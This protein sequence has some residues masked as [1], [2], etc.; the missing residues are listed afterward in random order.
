MAFHDF[1]TDKLIVIVN[2][3][4]LTD[5]GENDPP[6][7]HDFPSELGV[8]RKGMGGGAARLDLVEPGQVFN[9]YLQPGSPDSAFISV[10]KLSRAT[11]TIAHSQLGTLEAGLGR[12]GMIKNRQSSGRGGQT[13]TDDVF[14]IECNKYTDSTGG[15]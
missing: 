8:M 10:L 1:S 3:R 7:D 13:I 2:G 11:I 9:L 14:T 6:F 4:Q 15:L 5:W 12:E